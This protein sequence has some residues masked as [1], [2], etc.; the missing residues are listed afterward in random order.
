LER[1]LIIDFC[2][3][4]KVVAVE[5]VAERGV[6]TRTLIDVVHVIGQWLG[7]VAPVANLVCRFHHGMFADRLGLVRTR[8]PRKSQ[9]CPDYALPDDFCTLGGIIKYVF[10]KSLGVVIVFLVTCFQA[11]L[12]ASSGFGKT[13]AVVKAAIEINI[14]IAGVPTVFSLVYR[15]RIG[16]C[17][18]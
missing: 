15:T 10:C 16:S 4:S 18:S 7:G 17:S 6:D 5:G 3:L 1:I 2:L 12:Q 8:F 11:Q 14:R 9:P 13:P